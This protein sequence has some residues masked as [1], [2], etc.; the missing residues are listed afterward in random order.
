MGIVFLLIKSGKITMIYDYGVTGRQFMEFEER[1]FE[2]FELDCV[3][4]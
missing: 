3:Q 2:H 1:H 4:A